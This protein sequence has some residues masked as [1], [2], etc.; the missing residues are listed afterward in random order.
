MIENNYFPGIGALILMIRFV[1][2]VVITN[3]LKFFVALVHTLGSL[4][5][6]P[7]D[8]L[9]CS[10]YPGARE[11]YVGLVRFGDRPALHYVI[12]LFHK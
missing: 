10:N 1:F 8:Y 6:R 2:A 4:I 9:Q 3:D 5:G 7:D 11:F 12:R